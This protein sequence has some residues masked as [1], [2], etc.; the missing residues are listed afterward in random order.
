MEKYYS[1]NNYIP[2]EEYCNFY[3]LNNLTARQDMLGLSRYLHDLGV[4]L[5]F[6]DDPTFKHYLILKSELTPMFNSYNKN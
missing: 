2:L 6:Q 1:C 3:Q 5:H 4:C